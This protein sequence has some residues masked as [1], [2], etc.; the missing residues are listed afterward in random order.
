MPDGVLNT[1]R[2]L[3]AAA[4]TLKLVG[5]NI[6][7]CKKLS[8]GYTAGQRLNTN[9]GT[10]SVGKFAGRWVPIWGGVCYFTTLQQILLILW[11]KLMGYIMKK[12][13][14]RGNG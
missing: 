3:S 9:N 2:N 11:G 8:V 7:S 12:I 5:C 14:Y 6:N 13:G 1:I 10:K 4:R